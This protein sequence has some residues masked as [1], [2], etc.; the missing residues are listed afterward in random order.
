M[1]NALEKGEKFDIFDQAN[2]SQEKILPSF[3]PFSKGGL[4]GNMD[5]HIALL[6]GRYL[7]ILWNTI[8]NLMHIL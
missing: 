5:T 7:F 4:E 3:P 2:F 6:P 8:L 1:V